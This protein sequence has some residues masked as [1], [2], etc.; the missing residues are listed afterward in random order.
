MREVPKYYLNIPLT[1][2]LYKNVIFPHKNLLS[3]HFHL[4]L[5]DFK[6]GSLNGEPEKADLSRLLK[7]MSHDGTEITLLITAPTITEPFHKKGQFS[8]GVESLRALKR[9]AIY[10]KLQAMC[11][12]TK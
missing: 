5:I 3:T 10:R 4:D 12:A 1:F 9:M 11:D 2:S 6:V 8:I 7:F